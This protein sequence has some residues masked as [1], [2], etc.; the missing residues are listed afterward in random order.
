MQRR[1][2]TH[3]GQV[4]CTAP[5][6][7]LRCTQH[8]ATQRESRSTSTPNEGCG[9]GATAMRSR[10][11]RHVSW[12]PTGAAG[13]GLGTCSSTSASR[14]PSRPPLEWPVTFVKPA[15]TGSP[16]GTWVA[17][18]AQQHHQLPQALKRRADTACSESELGKQDVAFLLHHKRV[19]LSAGG[20]FTSRRVHFKAC[21]IWC[22][23]QANESE[24]ER[25][26]NL[27][28]GSTACQAAARG[29]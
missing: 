8:T 29:T 20:L 3:Q 7:S 9:D 6:A 12:I 15:Y 27:E 22:I 23:I 11:A 25:T 13:L 21:S 14:P 2:V 18:D 16:A 28:F 10:T 17:G 24:D 4:L 19:A 5:G 1:L 26:L